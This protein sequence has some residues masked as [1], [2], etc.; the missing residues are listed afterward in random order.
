MKL[1]R[2]EVEKVRSTSKAQSI[3]SSRNAS[4]LGSMRGSRSGSVDENDSSMQ[5][6]F[7]KNK[8]EPEPVSKG[9]KII[10]KLLS[11]E[12]R[13]DAVMELVPAPFQSEQ[14][15]LTEQDIRE[16]QQPR[17]KGSYDEM[18]QEMQ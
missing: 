17:R 3:V 9:G 18:D 6:I 15:Y 14:T 2:G 5:D 16:S 13:D 12:A 8:A 11:G 7:K 10:N 4:R 1:S